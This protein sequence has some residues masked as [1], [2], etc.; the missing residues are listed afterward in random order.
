MMMS[1]GSK[2]NKIGNWT[3]FLELPHPSSSDDDE[4]K[5]D[6]DQADCGQA[7]GEDVDPGSGRHLRKSKG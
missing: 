7:D 2:L 6:D 1:W 3:V 5:H 4:Q